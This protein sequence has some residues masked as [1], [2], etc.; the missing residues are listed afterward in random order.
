MINQRR[1]QISSRLQKSLRQKSSRKRLI[2]YGLIAANVLVLGAVVTFVVTS[3][4]TDH[5]GASG[6]LASDQATNPVDGLTSYDI[7]ANVA[8]MANLPEGTPI[9]NQA[10]SAQ[11]TIEVS[12]SD[13]AVVSKP[14]IVATSLKSRNDIQTYVVTTGDTIS[15]I[16]QRFGI[17]SNSIKWSNGLT[18]DTVALGT[19]LTI[20]PMNGLVYT[21]KSG[22]TVQS[23]ATKFK[24]NAD[25]IVQSNDAE[26]AGIQT[27]EQVLIPGG[28]VPAITSGYS[29]IAFG[30]FTPLYGGNGY[31]PGFCTWYV[32]TQVAIPANWGNA[33][34]WAYYAALSGWTV[35]ST[36]RVGAIAQTSAGYLGHVAV[37][38]A[39]SA[40][41]TQIQYRDMNGIAGFG[42]VGYSG[43]VPTTHFQHYIYH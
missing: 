25:A 42:K 31:D 2:R 19:K 27:G 4:H 3:S 16:A 20:P 5:T 26:L 1:L 30:S 34:T 8:R 36:P 40:D 29:G 6:S 32:A 14:Q 7:A 22:D 11:A 37:V 12:T 17:T 24:A 28:Q 35:S 23:L 18:S 39:V 43:W 38:D 9:N 15:S 21:V 13:T 33:N 41:G 10:Q